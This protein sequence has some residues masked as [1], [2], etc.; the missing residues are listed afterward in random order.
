MEAIEPVAAVMIAVKKYLEGEINFEK[1]NL[2]FQRYSEIEK[3]EI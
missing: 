2:I 1:Y 3:K